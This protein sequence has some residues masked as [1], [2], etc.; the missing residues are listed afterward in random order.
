MVAL[1]ALVLQAASGLQV[2]LVGLVVAATVGAL[3]L[4]IEKA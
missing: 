3:V 4:P 1:A 2:E